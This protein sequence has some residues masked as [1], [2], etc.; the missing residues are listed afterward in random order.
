MKKAFVLDNK[1]AQK[2]FNKKVKT[3]T[4]LIKKIERRKVR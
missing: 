1:K 3:S 2:F 4:D